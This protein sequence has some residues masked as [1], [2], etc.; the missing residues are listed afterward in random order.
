MDWLEEARTR[1]KKG[2]Q[3]LFTKNS[4]CLQEIN[5]LFQDQ[6]HRILILWAFE[7]AADSVAELARKYPG[8]R[9]SGQALEA[10][11][12]WAAGRVKMRLAQRRILD[13]HGLAKELTDRGDIALC[14]AVG[15]ACS[16]VH[17][18]GHAIGYPIYDLTGIVYRLGTE[19][20]REAV[21]R[22]MRLYWERLLFWKD[23]VGEYSDTWAEFL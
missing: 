10:A 11:R 8:E 16:V 22:R 21:E 4:E 3:I 19:R 6:E 9:R 23:H 20:C 5:M 12:D 14:H 13:C 17:T 2:N 7:F 18:A 15:Q 1:L